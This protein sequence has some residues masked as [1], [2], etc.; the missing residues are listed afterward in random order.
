[1]TPEKRELAL[2]FALGLCAGPTYLL[3]G[4]DRF[5]MWYGILSGGGVVSTTHWLRDLRPSR[6]AWLVWLAWPFVLL[7]GAALGLGLAAV[8]RAFLAP[9]PL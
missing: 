7:G 5:F 4:P 6:S 9:G 2:A 3:A 1:M 8:A